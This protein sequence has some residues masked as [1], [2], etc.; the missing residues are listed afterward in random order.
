[1]VGS[2]VIAIVGLL[3][4]L[5]LEFAGT[6]GPVIP[7]ALLIVGT[8]GLIAML[9]PYAAESFPLRSGGGPSGSSPPAPRGA[10]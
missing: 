7:V 9:L 1:M 4:V 6:G 3:G 5:G 10:E 2:I 8:D